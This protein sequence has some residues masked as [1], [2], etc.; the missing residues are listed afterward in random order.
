MLSALAQRL[1]LPAC[2]QALTAAGVRAASF[3]PIVIEQTSR[4]ERAYDIF[5]RCGC[6]TAWERGRDHADA[7]ARVDPVSFNDRRR[8]LLKERIIVINGG[9]G[10]F[11]RASAGRLRVVGLPGVRRYV[12]HRWT[13]CARCASP[14][15]LPGVPRLPRHVCMKADEMPFLRCMYSHATPHATRRSVR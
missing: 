5:S 11:Q 7:F 14:F 8:R 13:S 6:G 12:D 9:I 1:L 3:V 2:A 15:L 4:G 10:G